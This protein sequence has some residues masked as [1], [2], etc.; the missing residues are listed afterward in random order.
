MDDLS[1]DLHQRLVAAFTTSDRLRQRWAGDVADLR[2]AGRDC[3]R[4]GQDFSLAALLKGAGLAPADTAVCLLAFDHGSAF[5]E[6]KHPDGRARLRYVAR[7][8]LR[9]SGDALKR[10]SRRHIC[11]VVSHLIRQRLA[12]EEIRA[13]V[14]AE[15]EQHG[16]PLGDADM[17][18]TWVA[19]RE[20]E[21]RRAAP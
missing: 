15:A 9:A 5:D 1:G 17:L 19:Q 14:R 10:E 21:R 20:V 18:T 8:A 2:I 6:T 12:E 11:R 7:S 13:T 4:S 16:I 3:S